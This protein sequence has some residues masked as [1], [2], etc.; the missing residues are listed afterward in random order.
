[1]KDEVCVTLS[2]PSSHIGKNWAM[3]SGNLLIDRACIFHLMWLA[4]TYCKSASYLCKTIR[5]PIDYSGNLL[6][7]RTLNHGETYA[8]DRGN[9]VKHH[10]FNCQPIAQT[11][12]IFFVQPEY[13]LFVNR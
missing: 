6:C 5:L 12:I 7:I 9:Y 8:K 4:A 11:L 3:K 2:E 1:M 10:A 13:H